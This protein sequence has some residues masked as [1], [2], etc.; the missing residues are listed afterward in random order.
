MERNLK[1][2][3][4]AAELVNLLKKGRIAS[5]G[6]GKACCPGHDDINP[7]LMIKD[8]T[9]GN[10]LLWCQTGCSYERI[11]NSLKEQGISVNSQSKFERYPGLPEGIYYK[12]QGKDYVSH[13]TYR[14]EKSN[15]VG[16]MVRYESASGEKDYVP[17]FKREGEK[18]QP[19]FSSKIRESRPLYNLDEI[20]RKPEESVWIC[21]GEKCCDSLSKFGLLATTSTGG[22][23]AASKTDWSPLSGR[24]V[25][26]WPDNDSPGKLYAS[27]V[28]NQLNA[29]CQSEFICEQIDVDQIGLDDKQDAFDFIGKG[30]VKI[31][32]I[33]LPRFPIN[34]ISD[35]GVVTVDMAK[36]YEAMDKAE[37]L[38]LKKAPHV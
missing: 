14:D 32:I 18:W 33:T 9:Q 5:S 37:S 26:I 36:L 38:L 22:A 3:H 20:L 27:N 8:G 17:F 11:V 15:A 6:Q 10:I 16:F 12:F 31:D 29:I 28:F 21:E 34:D 19:G 4:N 2:V 23:N 30:N 13:Y 24:H 7:S 25:I 35:T 1:V